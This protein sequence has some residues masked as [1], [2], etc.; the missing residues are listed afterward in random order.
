MFIAIIKARDKNE[1]EQI[2]VSESGKLLIGESKK[3]ADLVLEKH[4]DAT[5]E[6]HVHEVLYP[7]GPRVG[8][9]AAEHRTFIYPETT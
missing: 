1:Q 6:V 4:P 8:I 5:V 7:D 2:L 9:M 3:F